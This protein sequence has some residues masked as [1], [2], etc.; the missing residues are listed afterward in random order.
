ML[1]IPSDDPRPDAR[2]LE[3]AG[4]DRRHVPRRL[5]PHRRLRRQ[6]A[7]GYLW[8]IGRRD[9]LINSFGY[10][11]SPHEVERVLASIRRCST[12]RRSARRWVRARWSSRRGIVPRPG[13]GLDADTLLAYG[14]TR[15]ASYK[16][17]RIVHM[18]D[19]LPRT[20][21]GKLLRRA[22][23]DPLTD[24]VMSIEE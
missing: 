5:V 4:G 10:R 22:L 8:F 21:N 12:R 17:P 3:S 18:V 2:L 16:A 19:Q 6:D 20:R 14:R 15:L 7:D 24:D 13:S 11:V 9:D 23:L 1:C